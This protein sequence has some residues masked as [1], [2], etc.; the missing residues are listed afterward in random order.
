MCGF[1]TAEGHFGPYY[2]ALLFCSWTGLFLCQLIASLAP[3]GQAAINIFPVSLFAAVIF[4]GY[5]IFIPEFPT[6][7]EAWGPYVSFMRFGFQAMVL[8]ELVGNPDLSAY[9]NQF[10]EDLGFDDYSREECL[11]I[12]PV[13]FFLTFCFGIL[14]ALKYVNWEER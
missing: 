13:V 11:S 1:T 12:I 14:L 6:W 3:T 2:C 10:I 7:L 5:I 9:S 8:N 4:A